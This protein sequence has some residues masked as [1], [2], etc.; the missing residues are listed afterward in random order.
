M[1]GEKPEPADEPTDMRSCRSIEWYAEGQAR[2]IEIGGIRVT[3]QFVGR[4][5]RRARIAITAPPGAVFSA[6]EEKLQNTNGT[7]S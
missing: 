4:K 5:G 2:I 7:A 3:V 1:E 6:A